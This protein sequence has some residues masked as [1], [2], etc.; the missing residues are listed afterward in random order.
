MR[1]YDTGRR[2]KAKDERPDLVAREYVRHWGKLVSYCSYL[3]GD[4]EAA[5]E[6][7]QESFLRLTG[8]IKESGAP[9]SARDWLFICARNLCYKLLRSNRTRAGYR[10]LLEQTRDETSVEDRR[11]L[12]EV[13]GRMEPED[14]DLILLREVEQYSIGELATLIGI[15]EGAIRVR[16]YRIR[17][18][19]QELG[20]K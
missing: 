17:K 14:R 9:E 3:T 2:N 11:F 12:Q 7:V 13:L 19:M 1:M 20:R 10:P 18:T 15:S 16:L 8:M 5:S 4:H 6:I